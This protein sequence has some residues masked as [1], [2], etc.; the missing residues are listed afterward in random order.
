MEQRLAGGDS[1]L[2]ALIGEEGEDSW[3]DLLADT[4]PDAGGSGGRCP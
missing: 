2:N 1:S 4:R 3:Q